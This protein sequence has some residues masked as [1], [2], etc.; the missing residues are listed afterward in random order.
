MVVQQRNNVE[1]ISI[2]NREKIFI[3][4]YRRILSMLKRNGE[5]ERVRALKSVGRRKER[6]N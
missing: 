5:K 4:K 1:S 3:G 2:S 6:K